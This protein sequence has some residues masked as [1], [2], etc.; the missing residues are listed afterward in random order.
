MTKERKPRLSK[1]QRKEIMAKLLVPRPNVSAIAKEYN[2]TPPTIYG[3][4]KGMKSG[5]AKIS[6][7]AVLQQEIENAEARIAY[8]K[9]TV[10]EI[11]ALEAE[12]KIKRDFLNQL[13]NLESKA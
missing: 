11:K 1:E 2:V 7:T 6:S 10:E 8:L 13:R 5:T 9:K 4:Q 3:I 12:I